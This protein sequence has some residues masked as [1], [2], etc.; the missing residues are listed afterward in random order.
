MAS[1]EDAGGRYQEPENRQVIVP[2][3]GGMA[4]FTINIDVYLDTICPWCYL[5]KKALNQAIATY[6]GQ[7]PDTT[8]KLTWKPY[9]LY[10]NAAVSGKYRY[11]T[12]EVHV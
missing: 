10:P 9:M 5:G 6:T 8:F 11:T 7:H 3:E 1:S 12:K 2:S 4:K